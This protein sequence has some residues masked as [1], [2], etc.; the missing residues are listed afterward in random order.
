MS[1]NTI[2]KGTFILTA[3]GLITRFIGFFFRIFLSHT[4]GEE[5]MGLYQLI[6]PIYALCFSLSSAGIETALSRC[7]AKKMAHGKKKEADTLLYQALLL[8]LSL[9]IILGLLVQRNSTFLAIHVLGDLRCEALL[10]ILSFALPFAA[11]HSC[12]CGYYFGHKQTNLPALSQFL[13]QI[14]RVGSIFIICKLLTS[15]QHEISIGIAVL[16]LAIGEFMSALF[17][18]RYFFIRPHHS[19]SFHNIWNNRKLSK[20]L[21]SLAIPLTSN[22]VLMNILQSIET[23]SIPLC[24]QNHGLNNSEALS[25]YGVLTGMA[26]PCILFPTALTN[27]VSTMLLPTVAEIEAENNLMKLKKIIQKV[28]LFGFG[29]GIICGIVFLFLGDFVGAL[30]FDSSLAGDFIKTLSWICPFMYMNTTLIS[31]I[32]GLGKANTSFMINACGLTIRILG[33]W[34]GISHW[35]M[36]GYLNGLLISQLTVSFLCIS[37]LGLYVKRREFS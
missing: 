34:F 37:Q 28:I 5:Q 26:M 27:S 33:V 29:L 17:C 7:V 15:N 18:T 20:E 23:I 1:K 30:L 25:T 9:A 13:E 11:I 2:I 12:I 35:G 8:S 16:G 24:L 3:T 14:S 31:I 22:R 10:K 4:F 6:F 19:F 36:N 21:F 32:N